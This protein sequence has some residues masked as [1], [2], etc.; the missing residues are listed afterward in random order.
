[1]FIQSTGWLIQSGCLVVPT[2]TQ[3]ISRR[4]GLHFVMAH[5]DQIMHFDLAT[6]RSGPP[7]CSGR[8]PALSNGANVED[9]PV[10]GNAL[11]SD[12]AGGNSLLVRQAQGQPSS[13]N[14]TRERSVT[15]RRGG[16]PI[17]IRS[18]SSPPERDRALDMVRMRSQRQ[19][20]NDAQYW[21]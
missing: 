6:S 2:E 4:I 17:M 19:M 3:V 13:F 7:Q 1:M 11:T 8:P 14:P 16:P 21:M 18:G 10:R 20:P 5:N 9:G 12:S 15:P